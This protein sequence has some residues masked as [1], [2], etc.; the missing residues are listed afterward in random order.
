M[1]DVWRRKW[2]ERGCGE[3]VGEHSAEFLQCGINGCRGTGD[4]TIQQ[5]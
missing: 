4:G 2:R 5:Q 3:E 1:R